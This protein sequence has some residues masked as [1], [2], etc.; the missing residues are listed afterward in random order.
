[1]RRV[2]DR[3]QRKIAKQKGLAM[4]SITIDE[5]TVDAKGAQITR[6]GPVTP[7]QVQELN[8]FITKW[9]A[10]GTEDDSAETADS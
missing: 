7:E 1:M 3:E 8:A 2:G 4:L 6:T 9:F 5:S 10:S